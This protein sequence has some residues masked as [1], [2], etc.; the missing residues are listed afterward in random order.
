MELLSQHP[1]ILLSEDINLA[2]FWSEKS[3]CTSIT[4]WFFYQIGLL[5]EALSYCNWVHNY[6]HDVFCKQKDYY[7]NL[8]KIAKS[9]NI[10][11]VKLVRNPFTRVVSSYLTVNDSGGRPQNSW[12]RKERQ[13][14]FSYLRRPCTDESSFS[15]RE[16]VFYLK[17]SNIEQV[18]PHYRTQV[19]PAEKAELIQ[20]DYLVKLENI[21]NQIKEV[22]KE[23]SL[24]DSDI[25]QLSQSIHHN[26]KN[27][28]LKEFVG[29]KH[30]PFLRSINYQVPSNIFFYDKIITDMVFQIYEEDFQRYGYSY[31]NLDEHK[32]MF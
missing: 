25:D 3:G 23:L 24:K 17:D 30:F 26:T 7:K 32:R 28:Q 16:F 6:R 31:E 29:D 13:K 21:K 27:P 9:P 18:N 11:K 15:F 4:K 10:K 19:H 2:V 8:S 20:I 1:I 5:E 22:E 14:I 12:Q